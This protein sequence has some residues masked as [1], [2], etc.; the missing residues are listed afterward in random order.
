MVRLGIEPRTL[1]IRHTDVNLLVFTFT[2]ISVNLGKT[3]EK[4]LNLGIFNSMFM[5]TTVGRN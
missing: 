3:K 1:Y 4:D 2:I 5:E